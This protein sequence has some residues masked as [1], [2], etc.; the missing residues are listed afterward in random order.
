M[1]QDQKRCPT[2]D[3]PMYRWQAKFVS[4]FSLN[5]FLAFK[6]KI[7]QFF[8]RI[9]SLLPMLCERAHLPKETP[10]MLFEASRVAR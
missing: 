1:T 4:I 10:L 9:A 5:S 6:S 3:M 2:V 7:K 8:L